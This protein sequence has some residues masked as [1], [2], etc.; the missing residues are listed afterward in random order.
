MVDLHYTDHELAALYDVECPWE[1]RDD[2]R[3]YLPHV[4]A[5]RSVLDVGCGTGMLLRHA[6]DAG[7]DGR[8]VGLDPAEGMLAVARARADVDWVHG[9]LTT[10]GFDREFEFAVMTG[11]AFQVLV[12]DDEL[13]TS[14]AGA[15]AALT[16]DGGRFA[17][18]TRNPAA[19]RWESWRRDE[20]HHVIAP[21][22]AHVTVAYDVTEVD[23]ELVTF[24]ATYASPSWERDR[25]SWSTLRFLD[26]DGLRHHLGAAGLAIDE[27]RG[28]W[29]GGALTAASPE[30][31]VFAR[32]A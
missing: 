8:L 1:E 28:D 16:E 26:L 32:A 4:L 12:T 11:H 7:H 21:D 10:A 6:R 15:R 3:F 18:E 14:L 23:G 25:V 9:D 29:H 20:A 24:S 30:I 17:F 22:G 31:I 27:V 13:H 19:R 2:F 5:A